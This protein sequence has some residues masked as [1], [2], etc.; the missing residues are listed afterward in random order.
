MSFQVQIDPNAHEAMAEADAIGGGGKF[1]PG[2]RGEYQATIVPLKKDDPNKRV[3]VVDFA[4]RGDN[5]GKKALR[6]AF[7]IV[8]ESPTLSKRWLSARIP[9]FMRFAPTQKNP[10]GAPAKAYF[11]FWKALGVSEEALLAGN[12]PDVNFM[13][14]KRIGLVLSDPIEPDAY[15]PLG[16][17]EIAFFNKPGDISSTPRRIDGQSVA[18]WLTPTDEL[19]LDYNFQTPEAQAY[20]ATLT[21]AAP[22]GGGAASP[23]G[24]AGP[25]PSWATT[26]G[27][28]APQGAPTPSWAQ[29]PASNALQQAALAGGGSY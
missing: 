27:G 28:A 22:T 1:P 12:L 7:Q 10:K 18:P 9:L 17:N 29:P 3:E 13:M 14:G 21:G 20:V 26:P 8:P 4:N 16:Q 19:I 6:V 23:A 24:N 25:Q 5:A 2:P 11:D 15:N